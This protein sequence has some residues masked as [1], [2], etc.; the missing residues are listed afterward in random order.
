M[1]IRA[2]LSIDVELNGTDDELLLANV[3]QLIN[4]AR[5]HGLITGNTEAELV[6]MQSEVNIVSESVEFCRCCGSTAD[7]QAGPVEING[8]SAVQEGVCSH[9]GT[10]RTDV[11]ALI[12]QI[13][14]E[15][16]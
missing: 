10:D 9:C 14:G 11:F 4:A 16:G 8:L 3:Q 5:A 15:Q 1:K 2:L 13:D 12:R 7:Y 6:D